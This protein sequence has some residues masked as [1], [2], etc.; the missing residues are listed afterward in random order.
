[1]HREGE[2]PDATLDAYI[3]SSAPLPDGRRWFAAGVNWVPEEL[4]LSIVAYCL[5]ANA[6][7]TYVVR[8]TDVTVIDDE[9][10]P[11]DQRCGRGRRVVTGGAFWHQPGG[12]PDPSVEGYL[13]SSTPDGDGKGWYAVGD[14]RE[15]K[16]RLTFI[17][18]CLPTG[19]IGPYRL[20]TVD[21][22]VEASVPG[23]DDLSC[24]AGKRAVQGGAYW[25][26]PGE[27]RDPT[28]EAWLTSN[29]PQLGGRRWY[30]DGW[31]GDDVAVRLRI[32]VLCL[33]A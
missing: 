1:V 28:M 20:R 21:V 29:A 23:G 10:R 12:P 31:N 18:L 26:R 3:A 22:P 13:R 16:L 19:S 9:V 27:G 7:G 33:P 14:N 32:V 15:P 24:G 25:H 11:K 2:G 8:R 6:L 5:P 17:A 4:I 30:A